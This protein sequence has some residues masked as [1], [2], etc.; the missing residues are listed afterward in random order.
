M[1]TR[2]LALML[3]PA[4]LAAP[5][6]HAQPAWPTKP[7][8]VI[9]PFAPG[10]P[11]DLIGRLVAE[12]LGQEIGGTAVVENRPGAN[13]NIGA[14]AAAADG[15]GHTVLFST[16]TMYTLNPTLY[17]TGQVDIARDCAGLA[18]VA[19]LPNVLIV[20]PKKRDV[21]SVQQLIAQ[22]RQAPGTLTY[23]TFGLGSSPH[24]TATLLQQ[25]GGFEAVNVPYGG[26]APALNAVLAGDVD[27]LFDS[28]TT[29]TPQIQA[30]AV[31][32]LGV[33]SG[34]R[35][36]GLPDVP[37][38]QEAGLAGFEFSGWFAAFASRK[39]PAV[40]LAKLRAAVTAAASAPDYAARLRARG[41]E[42]F[43]TP[44]GELDAFLSRE[45]ERWVKL[46]QE[47]GIRRE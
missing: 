27:F 44:D 30:G 1:L 43:V 4:V 33:T 46:A 19:A 35:T 24:V 23:A 9:V 10:G 31:R 32:A 7:V 6:L 29:S 41:A 5:A 3:G 14:A 21:S 17:G 26:S 8:R 15:D 25:L 16:G 13:G 39:T 38:L 18:T 2:R 22:G 12:R 42:P 34:F 37:T 40:V 20:N 47:A 45:K 36:S 28:V 11:T